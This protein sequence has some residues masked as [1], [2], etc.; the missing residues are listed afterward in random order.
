MA[1]PQRLACR[2]IAAQDLL[3]C[4]G[5]SGKLVLLVDSWSHSLSG[6]KAFT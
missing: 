5:L 2:L 6:A 4:P 3:T 1:F